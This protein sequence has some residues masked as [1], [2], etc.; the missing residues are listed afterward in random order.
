MKQK[1]SGSVSNVCFMLKWSVHLLLPRYT[2]IASSS[3]RSIFADL[4]QEKMLLPMPG[5]CRTVKLQLMIFS[6]P[7]PSTGP[8]RESPAGI[9]KK[10]KSMSHFCSATPGGM[11]W[12]GKV[13]SVTTE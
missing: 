1:H 12:D 13:A 6:P 3:F 9:E 8:S 10:K 2:I 4:V 5:A 11:E 7:I